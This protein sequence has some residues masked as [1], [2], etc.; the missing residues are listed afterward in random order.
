MFGLLQFIILSLSFWKVISFDSVW[1]IAEE[2][3]GL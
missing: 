3:Y 2:L 1:L